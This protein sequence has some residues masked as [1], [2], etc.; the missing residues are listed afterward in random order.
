MTVVIR[1]MLS[2][3]ATTNQINRSDLEGVCLFFTGTAS[4][5][6]TS[7]FELSSLPLRPSDHLRDGGLPSSAAES[8]GLRDEDLSSSRFERDRL[9]GGGF[10][11]SDK[12]R[13][14]EGLFEN[15]RAFLNED[16]L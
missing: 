9:R 10:L 2:S 7:D 1:S 4:T 8:E 3:A 14:R 11:S 6:F 16:G 12:D 5:S 13:L 15:S